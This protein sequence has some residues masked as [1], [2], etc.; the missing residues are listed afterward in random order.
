MRFD[1]RKM[2]LR[3]FGV[4]TAWDVKSTEIM[5]VPG[6]GPALTKKLTDWRS[7]IEKAF[8]F[9]PNLPT[10]P[11]EIAKV[12]LEIAMRRSAMET[13]LL[14]G[15]KELEVLRAEA[16]AKRNDY[17]AYQTVYLAMRQAEIDATLLGS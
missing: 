2:T 12:R 9:N 4:E 3:S 8:K 1:G 13:A 14:Q 15:A 6:F 17:R 7:R 5:A 11:G 16:L 10:D